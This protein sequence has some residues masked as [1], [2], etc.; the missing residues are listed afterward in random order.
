MTKQQ[1]VPGLVSVC[2][3]VHNRVGFLEECLASLMGQ[4]Y[5]DIEIIAV[6]DGSQDG[7]FEYLQDVN[8]PRLKVVRNETARG[9]LVARRQALDRSTG[10][11]IAI[12]DDDDVCLDR[13]FETQVEALCQGNYDVCGSG[14]SMFHDDSDDRRTIIFPKEQS[15]TVALLCRLCSIWNPTVIFRHSVLARTGQFY[16][17]EDY[18]A[19]DWALWR[20]L[21]TLPGVRFVNAQEVLLDYRVHPSQVT[22]RTVRSRTVAARQR[23]SMLQSLGIPR[24]H[25]GLKTHIR[26]FDRGSRY[27]PTPNELRILGAMYLQCLDRGW[28]ASANIQR[29]DLELVFE[30]CLDEARTG[31]R[32]IW[33]I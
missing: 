16:R 18:P 20:R 6:D 26:C 10:E 12:M 3:T 2:L 5:A 33:H 24:R 1:R 17:Q 8:D 25:P 14:V 21:L 27:E 30:R 19:A 15:L 11:F 29:D 9:G 7:S 23:Y 13:R 31:E 4:T 32:A 22:G 28:Y